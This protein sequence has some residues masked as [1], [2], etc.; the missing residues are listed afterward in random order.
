M[1]CSAVS[2]LPPGWC[3]VRTDLLQGWCRNDIVPVPRHSVH[4]MN[5]DVLPVLYRFRDN[6]VVQGEPRIR[7][8]VG[9]P[10][11]ASNGHRLGTL[12][13]LGPQPRVTTAQEAMIL[14]NMAGARTRSSAVSCSS[15][16]MH[17]WTAGQQPSPCRK[18]RS[19]EG[20]CR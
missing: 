20:H 15:S 2:R 7:F 18:R 4:H 8:F 14:A 16:S 9:A 10:L 5:I 13:Y 6:V 19:S 17:G 1:H 11:V 12:C 3:V